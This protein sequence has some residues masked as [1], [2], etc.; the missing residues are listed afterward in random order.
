MYVRIHREHREVAFLDAHD[1][2]QLYDL[3]CLT[4]FLFAETGRV[5]RDL[6]RCGRTF[7]EAS[8]ITPVE[9]F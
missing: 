9:I 4:D 6:Q 5:R 8:R 1:V 3:I 7:F 2:S